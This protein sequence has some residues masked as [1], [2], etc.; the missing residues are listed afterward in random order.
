MDSQCPPPQEFLFSV[1]EQQ[2]T[3]F[4]EKPE[5]TI[6]SEKSGFSMFSH[7]QAI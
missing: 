2:K 1:I 5:G 7:M 4:S 3:V 6:R